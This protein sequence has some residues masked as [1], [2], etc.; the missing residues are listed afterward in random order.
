VADSH[1]SSEESGLPSLEPVGE[2]GGAHVNP[3]SRSNQQGSSL[4][5]ESSA[6]DLSGL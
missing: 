5:L 2:M 1:H 4:A 3:P 6:A